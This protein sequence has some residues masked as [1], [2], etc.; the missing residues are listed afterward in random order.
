L[1]D[2]EFRIPKKRHYTEFEFQNQVKIDLAKDL[3]IVYRYNETQDK[4]VVY[5]VSRMNS[6]FVIT[7]YEQY[8][9]ILH[10]P[11]SLSIHRERSFVDKVLDAFFDYRLGDV[12]FIP[13]DT[14]VYSEV[15]EYFMTVRQEQ[16]NKVTIENAEMV[17]DILRPTGNDCIEIFHPEHGLLELQPTTDYICRTFTTS[18]D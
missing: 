13:L 16:F 5:V 2:I 17:N 4:A 7:G 6:C 8:Q 11:M 9:N 15:I 14:A 1:K 12:L 10:R 18:H 3:S